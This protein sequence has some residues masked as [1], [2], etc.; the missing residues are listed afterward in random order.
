MSAIKYALNDLTKAEYAAIG[1][2]VRTFG[3]IEHELVR[4]L[5]DANGGPNG[6]RSEQLKKA[7]RGSLKTRLEELVKQLD[8]MQN[9]VD[10]EWLSDFKTKLLE[11]C[12]VRDHYC[13][14]FW[15]KDEDGKLWCDFFRRSTQRNTTDELGVELREMSCS[16]NEIENTF[17]S[18]L[19]NLKV[20]ESLQQKLK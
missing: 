6:V 4:T 9:V 14:G 5:I 11:G 10:P 15:R 13:H 17:Q 1:R 7:L 2:V 18:N 20:L 3:A 16:L 19:K 12:Q 8:S